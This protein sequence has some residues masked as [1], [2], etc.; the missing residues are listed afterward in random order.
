MKANKEITVRI[1]NTPKL[2]IKDHM[3]HSKVKEAPRTPRKAI[4]QWS[5]RNQSKLEKLDKK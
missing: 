2:L 3:E 4:E 5:R 1:R